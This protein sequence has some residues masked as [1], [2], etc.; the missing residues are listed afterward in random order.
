MAKFEGRGHCAHCKRGVDV[1]SDKNGLAYY[2][3][4]PCGTKIMHQG[5]RESDKVL[6]GLERDATPEDAPAPKP[7]PPAPRPPAPV[8]P[9]VP[10]VPVPPAQTKKPGGLFA[11]FTL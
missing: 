7:A 5:R 2:K 10:P 1:Y 4:G 11:N 6:A 3:C 8:V 9:P